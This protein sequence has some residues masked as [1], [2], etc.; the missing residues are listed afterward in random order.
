MA[1]KSR[2]WIQR[3]IKH[4]GSLK[5]WAKEHRFLNRDGTIDLREAYAYAKRHGLT[6][7]M[8]QINLARNLKKLRKK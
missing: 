7:R 2:K 8:R 1:R 3:A 5:E 6:K 4:K